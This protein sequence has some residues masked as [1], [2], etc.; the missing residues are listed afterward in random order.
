MKTRVDPGLPS[1]AEDTNMD[2]PDDGQEPAELAADK[3]AADESE[4]EDEL[5][6][7]ANAIDQVV[8]R[9]IMDSKCTEGS[10]SN[11][12]ANGRL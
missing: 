3:P 6:A 5:V 4:K 2:A 11:A 9:A 10:V 8:V 7:A 12:S 1:S